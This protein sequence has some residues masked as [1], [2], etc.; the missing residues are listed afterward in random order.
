[1]GIRQEVKTPDTGQ[2]IDRSQ[3]D[4]EVAH[5]NTLRA[6]AI[7]NTEL[8][9]LSKDQMGVISL[10]RAGGALGLHLPATSSFFENI[11][12]LSSAED[13]IGRL[14]AKDC[15][16]AGS[17]PLG[18]LFGEKKTGIWE[19]V[20]NFLPGKKTQDTSQQQKAQ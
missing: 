12:Q 15:I 5:E 14:Q 19:T 2:H 13:G 1:M 3:I 18:L 7:D 9:N 8:S 6:F 20:K 10:V 4:S 11:R 17:I 16:T